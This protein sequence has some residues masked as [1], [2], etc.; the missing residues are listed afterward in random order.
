MAV[1]LLFIYLLILFAL[2]I[3]LDSKVMEWIYPAHCFQ[4][5]NL[6]RFSKI[7]NKKCVRMLTMLFLM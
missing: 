6:C 1:S 3:K 5:F 2:Y 7:K 4:N